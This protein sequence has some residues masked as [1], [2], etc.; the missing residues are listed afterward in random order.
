MYRAVKIPLFTP[1]NRRAINLTN[2]GAIKQSIHPL[3]LETAHRPSSPF[4]RCHLPDTGPSVY[5]S[6]WECS[7]SGI[8][9]T[10]T[11]QPGNNSELV[12]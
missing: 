10:H 12:W 5:G 9:T 11:P 2:R 6:T 4:P 1:T 8:C 7:H 3:S